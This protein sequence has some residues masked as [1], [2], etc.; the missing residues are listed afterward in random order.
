MSDYWGDI[1]ESHKKKSMQNYEMLLESRRKSSVIS[2]A[3][4]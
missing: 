4:N 1:S 2:V 3:S